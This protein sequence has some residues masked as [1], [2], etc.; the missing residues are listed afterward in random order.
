MEKQS[1]LKERIT[2]RG[3]D[4]YG[5]L[6]EG[7]HM[8]FDDSCPYP[9][10]SGCP[11]G[12]LYRKMQPLEDMIEDKQSAD[13]I[14]YAKVKE[15][16]NSICTSYSKVTKLSDGRKKTIKARFNDGYTLED[17]ERLFQTAQASAFL[18]GENKRG[19]SAT[20]DWLINGN[21]MVRVLDG[22]Y[23]DKQGKAFSSGEHSYDLDKFESMAMNYTPKI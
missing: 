3:W 2:V 14:P 5:Q 17:F 15:L 8:G 23:N 18:R 20:F 21:S 10:C 4:Y 11:I 16:F 13:R 22:N 19:W 12:K 7:C 1:D 9:T 6:R